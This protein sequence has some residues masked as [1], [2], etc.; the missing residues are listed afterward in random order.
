MVGSEL[1]GLGVF[2]YALFVSVFSLL[3]PTFFSF[4]FLSFHSHPLPPSRVVT[5]V[6]CEQVPGAGSRDDMRLFGCIRQWDVI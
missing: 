1:T 4:P 6:L 5:Y 2:I 3:L